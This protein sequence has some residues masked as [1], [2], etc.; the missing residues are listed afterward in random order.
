MTH[1]QQSRERPTHS[2]ESVR[3]ATRSANQDDELTVLRFANTLLKRWRLAVW[4]PFI[5]GIAAVVISLLLPH[6]F[7]A[8]ATFRPETESSRLGLPGGLANI[9][10][11]FGVGVPRD[12]RSPSFY[13][14]LLES[15]TLRSEVLH[16]PLPDPK[17]PSSPDSATVLDRLL[18]EGETDEERLEAGRRFLAKAVT[19]RVD[20]GT[21]ILTLSVETRDPTLSAA[22]ANVALDRLMHFNLVSRQSSARERRVFVEGRVADTEDELRNAESEL[23]RFQERNRQWEGSP[24]L[25]LDYERL[26]RQVTLKQEVLLTLL[27][28]YEEARIQEVNETPVITV[29]DRAV[30]P[31][32]RSR[33]RRKL[34]V[35]ASVFLGVM[36]GVLTA[37]MAEYFQRVRERNAVDYDEFTTRLTDVRDKLRSLMPARRL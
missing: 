32:Y 13:A 15:R 35:G 11:Q 33:P 18:I 8:T 29:I 6:Q 30:P 4:V 16:M 21:G 31:Q 22:I 28:Q 12:T 19:V 25:R 1:D 3:V 34:I 20:A 27:R 14:K 17:D 36:F 2:P 24:A 9:A 23:R 10:S 5:F 26:Q 37:F 7:R